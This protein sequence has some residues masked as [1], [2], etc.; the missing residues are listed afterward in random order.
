V[1]RES[2]FAGTRRFS[3]RV[4]GAIHFPHAARAERREN[5]VQAEARVGGQGH[6]SILVEESLEGQ[7]NSG[8]PRNASVSGG[9]FGGRAR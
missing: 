9:F 1:E 3:S 4:F 5:F 8:H 2:Y 7:D 6:E